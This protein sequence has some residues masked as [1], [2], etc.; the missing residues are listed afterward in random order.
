MAYKNPK[1]RP[2]QTN[3]PVGS[4]AFKARMERQRARR[5]VDAKGTDANKN[6]KAD[7]REGRDVSHVKALSKGGKNKDGV[8][9]ESSSKNRAR[10]YKNTAKTG[11]K[12]AKSAVKKRSKRGK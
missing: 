4:A 11:G 5:A 12:I 6:G 10:N 3:N 9:I 2:K 8:K 7:K 1:D